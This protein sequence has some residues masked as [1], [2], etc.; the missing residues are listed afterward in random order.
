M[1]LT[2]DKQTKKPDLRTHPLLM[3]TE[4]KKQIIGGFLDQHNDV[5]HALWNCRTNNKRHRGR[6]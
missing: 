5:E 4:T 6:P 3:S 1:L 2:V